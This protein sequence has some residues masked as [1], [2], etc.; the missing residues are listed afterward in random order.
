MDPLIIRAI[1]RIIATLTGALLVY[2]GYRLFLSLP[3]QSDSQGKFIL[4]GNISIYMSRIG[5]GAFF[6]LFG[7]GVVVASFYF[8]MSIAPSND[9]DKKTNHISYIGGSEASPEENRA[10]VLGDVYIL[11]RTQKDP[12]AVNL[13]ELRPA[14]VRIKLALMH[15]VWDEKWGDYEKFRAWI[16]AGN[17]Q[18]PPSKFKMAFDFFSQGLK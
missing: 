8:S 9:V 3:D 6:A 14:V 17:Q 15:D 10:N 1:E 5:P 13:D 7:A 18:S 4:P 2:L 16:G 12:V 11:N